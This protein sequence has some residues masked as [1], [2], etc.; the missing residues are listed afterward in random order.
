LEEPGTGKF[1][2]PKKQEE[3]DK[4][5]GA[6]QQASESKRS[7]GAAYTA[8]EGVTKT[9]EFTGGEQ[10]LKPGDKGGIQGKIDNQIGGMQSDGAKIEALKKRGYSDKDLGRDDTLKQ[11]Y[12]Q[13]SDGA[14]YPN[15]NLGLY[16]AVVKKELE[17]PVDTKAKDSQVVPNETVDGKPATDAK[18]ATPAAPVAGGPAR[19]GKISNNG[20]DVAKT[21]TENAD[22]GREAGKGGANNTVVSNNVSSNNTTKIVPTK[23]NPRPDYTGSSLDRYTNRITVY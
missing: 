3:Y 12:I 14:K 19:G 1:K 23:A 21:S 5:K 9:Y 2:D 20:K 8:A 6:K 15:K 13:M 16:E 18:G 10:P 22:M 17:T 7:A 4:L 11:N